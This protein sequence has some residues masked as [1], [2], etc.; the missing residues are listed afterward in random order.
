MRFV[1]KKSVLW[2]AATAAAV[3]LN[4]ARVRAGEESTSLHLESCTVELVDGRKVEGRLAVRFDLPDHLV[5]YS[6][7]LAT[8]RSFLKTHVHALTVDG[9]RRELNPKRTLTDDDAE[10]LGGVAWPDEPPKEGPKPAHTSETWTKPRQLLVWARPG[11]SGRIEAPGNWLVNGRPMEEWPAPVGHH[12]GLIFFKSSQVD[13][14]FPAAEKPY[15]VRPRRSNVRARHIT[16]EAGADAELS[17][18]ECVGNLWVSA[19]G[20][21]NGGGGAHLAGDKH[22]FFVNGRP[23][24]GAPPTSPETFAAVMDAAKPFARKWVVRKTDP[25]ASMSLTGTFGSGDETH[26]LRGVTILE[27]DSVIAI[28]PRCVQ[29]VGWEATLV[30]KSGSVLGKRRNQLYKNDMRVKGR[31]WA[32]TPDEP[33]TG[34]C[35]LGISIKDTRGRA[36]SPARPARYGARGLT[37]APGGGIRVHTANPNCARLVVTWHGTEPGGDD[38]SSNVG[39]DKLPE[40]ERTINVNLL[41]RPVLSDVV[42]EYLGPGDL[43]LEDPA[44]QEEWRRVRFGEHTASQG[45]V[46]VRLQPDEDLKEEIARWREERETRRGDEVPPTARSTKGSLNPRIL[47]SG[48]TFAAGRPVEVRLHALGDPEMRYT[49]DGTDSEQGKPYAGPFTVTETTTV[50]AG[51][52]HYPGPHFRRRWEEVADTFTFAE[53]ARPPDAPGRTKPG[54]RLRVY[55]DN[56]LETKPDERGEPVRTATVERFRLDIADAEK[57]KA[58][59]YVYSG[60]VHVREP[61]VY[62][63]YA[64][65][66]G[67]SRL[68]IGDRLVVDNHRRYRKDYQDVAKAPLASW[69]SLRLEP[70]R[71][72]IRVEYARAY[73][74]AWWRPQE[75]EVFRVSYEGPGIEK[76]PI[77]AEVLSHSWDKE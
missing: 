75:D 66:E 76:Q 11:K 57:R 46:A 17:L 53:A 65:T 25:E 69:G 62:R 4:A 44:V 32:G 2:I 67:A 34:N 39:C 1:S 73:G 8:V 49:T 14:L 60:Y 36:T 74:F 19:G 35:Y 40:A 28:G 30:M 27:E 64:Q 72:A 21:F 29:T 50:K 61:G 71:H 3:C 70:G 16:V 38:G 10:L 54:L 48:G 58:A 51:L 12:Y 5:V 22:T 26:W 24:R 56:P 41:G 37:V 63:F 45:Q 20:A 7:R 42:F 33:L 6:P 77:P 68:F 52:F 9:E 15:K 55:E 31:L 18:N 43:R 47:P 59:G 13:F 23:Y